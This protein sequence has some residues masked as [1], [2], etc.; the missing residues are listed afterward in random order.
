LNRYTEE[1]LKER[2]QND[3]LKAINTALRSTTA[4]GDAAAAGAGD[5]PSAAA[6]AAKD[7]SVNS[8]WHGVSGGTL[9]GREVGIEMRTLGLDG[10]DDCVATTD[11]VEAEVTAWLHRNNSEVREFLNETDAED[12]AKVRACTSGGAVQVEFSC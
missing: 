6:A 4:D 7:G 3:F 1:L 5:A 10:K 11:V 12:V 2:T 9:S 8:G